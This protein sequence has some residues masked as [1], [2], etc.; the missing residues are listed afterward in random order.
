MK[1]LELAG[2]V[3]QRRAALQ[4]AARAGFSQAARA[5]GRPASAE[6]VQIPPGMTD[7]II[8]A[9]LVRPPAAPALEAHYCVAMPGL[10]ATQLFKRGGPEERLFGTKLSLARMPRLRAGLEALFSLVA[11]AGLDCAGPLGAP[12]PEKLVAGKTLGN[13]YIFFHFG[14][15]MPLLYAY[16]GDLSGDLGDP[17]EFIERRLVGPL[18]HELSHFHAEEVPAPGNLHEALAAYIGSEAWPAQL[19]PIGGEE[20]ALPGGAYFAAVGAWLARELGVPAVLRIQAGLLDLRDA[21]GPECAEALRLYGFLP[22]LE[23]G[24]PHLLSDAFHPGRWWKLINLY[25][26]PKCP[27]ALEFQ[28]RLVA[29]LQA[30]V[31]PP[32]QP[33]QEAWNAALDAIPWQELPAFSDPPGPL[34]HALAKRAEAA[35]R[36]RAE[37]QGMSFR[38][39]AHPEARLTLDREACELRSDFAGPDAVGAPPTHPYPP[40]LSRA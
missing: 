28:A 30:G 2:Q 14:R 1:L 33:L 15:S 35:L 24:A 6:F 37:R 7:A 21:L 8:A 17:R 25:K 34:D 39:R 13:L 38:A 20:D 16:P 32:G 23:S 31:P 40:S 11:S 36:T 18:L 22:F 26:L 19:Y 5:L 4:A 27:Q 9:G 10:L 3:V 29:P 12:T